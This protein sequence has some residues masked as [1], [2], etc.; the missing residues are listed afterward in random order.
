MKKFTAVHQK[1]VRPLPILARDLMNPPVTVDPEMY[2]LQAVGIMDQ[3]DFAQVPVT[4]ADQRLVGLLNEEVVRQALLYPPAQGV[5]HLRVRD[6]MVPAAPDLG[7]EASLAEVLDHL[8]TA[9][10]ALI[11]E[12]HRLVGIITRYDI[13]RLAQ[14]WLLIQEVELRLR[15]YV[16]RWLSRTHGPHWWERGDI[17]PAGMLRAWQR[18]ERRS[19]PEARPDPRLPRGEQLL[20][21]ATFGD[22]RELIRRADTTFRSAPGGLETFANRLAELHRARNLLAHNRTVSP[23]EVGAVVGIARA[24]VADL[25]GTDD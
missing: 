10:A 18:E 24:V 13:I 23:E 19:D 21:Y 5:S 20:Y 12:G 22:I 25:V 8:S 15:A 7:P 6:A 9:H 14:P 2:L 1:E 11:G 3:G 16:N 4:E 17:V